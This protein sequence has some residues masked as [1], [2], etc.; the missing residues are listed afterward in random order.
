MIHGVKENVNENTDKL[1]KNI[2]D[3]NVQA[4]LV[5]KD[6]TRTHRIGRKRNGNKPRPIIARFLSYR[7]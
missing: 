5:D 4:G 7:Q 2:C 1:V 6:I 3:T